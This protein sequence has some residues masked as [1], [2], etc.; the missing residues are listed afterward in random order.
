LNNVETTLSQG[1][2]QVVVAQVDQVELESNSVDGTTKPRIKSI[3]GLVNFV[4][5]QVDKREDKII[6]F[7]DGEEGSE[8]SGIN[9]GPLKF[10][11]RNK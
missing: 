3:G 10:K 5:A 4:I 6:E 7:R 11:N 8:V 2:K 9:L 1:D